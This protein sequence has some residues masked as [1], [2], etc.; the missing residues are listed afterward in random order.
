ME[1]NLRQSPAAPTPRLEP[2]LNAVTG[3]ARRPLEQTPRCPAGR[4]GITS[5][6][7]KPP[8]PAVLRTG[9]G[10]GNSPPPP[11]GPPPAC[12]GRDRKD[13]PRCRAPP[14]ELAAVSVAGGGDEAEPRRAAQRRAA[15]SPSRPRPAGGDADPSRPP[16][17]ERGARPACLAGPRQRKETGTNRDEEAAAAA[18]AAPPRA[19]AATPWFFTQPEPTPASG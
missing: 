4:G 1:I 19:S 11:A 7:P 5:P 14:P 2:F 15:H 16:T 9:S 6:L 3:A 18:T 13:E 8:L 12:G 17:R 10:A